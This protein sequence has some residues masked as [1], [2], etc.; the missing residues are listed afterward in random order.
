MA[1][2]G[3]DAPVSGALA[4]RSRTA[5]MRRLVRWSSQRDWVISSTRKRSCSVVGS[6]SWRYRARQASKS[7]WFSCGR[8]R[9][10]PVRPWLTAFWLEVALP[11]SVRGPVEEVAFF[12]FATICAEE[13]MDEALLSPNVYHASGQKRTLRYGISGVCDGYGWS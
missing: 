4:R 10:P 6:N 5:A 7:A 12:W 1:E 13:L 11:A 9:K 2:S 8:T 3:E